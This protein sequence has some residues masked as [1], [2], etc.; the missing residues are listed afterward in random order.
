MHK[1]LGTIIGISLLILISWFSLRLYKVTSQPALKLKDN[2]YS[3]VN[4]EQPREGH[5]SMVCPY[6]YCNKALLESGKI[7]ENARISRSPGTAQPAS[8]PGSIDGV[9]TY[10]TLENVPVRQRFQCQMQG[11]KV[12]DYQILADE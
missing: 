1:I 8:K 3:I 6:L 4:C 5:A 10:T 7:P 2:V 12:I 9:I 11:D